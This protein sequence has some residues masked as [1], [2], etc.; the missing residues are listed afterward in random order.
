MYNRTRVAQHIASIPFLLL[1]VYRKL[2]RPTQPR[3]I[4]P[5]RHIT[6][7]T[8]IRLRWPK[9]VYFHY[10]FHYRPLIENRPM[11]NRVGVMG[12]SATSTPSINQGTKTAA[13]ASRPANNANVVKRCV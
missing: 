6:V 13:G 12:P 11:A 5:P 1:A 3:L 10:R 7:A 2:H 4:L 9:R 8:A